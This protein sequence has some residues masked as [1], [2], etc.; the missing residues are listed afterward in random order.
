MSTFQ[1]ALAK[2]GLINVEA[3]DLS[4]LIGFNSDVTGTFCQS[5]TC[6]GGSD[7]PRLVAVKALDIC[8]LCKN[9]SF[10]YCRAISKKRAD[11][12]IERKDS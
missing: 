8:P 1:T 5:F 4:S 12:F 10:T 6:V 7:S 11:K 2:S 3:P 9:D